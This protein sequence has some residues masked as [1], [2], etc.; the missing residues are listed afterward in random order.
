[1]CKML[2]CYFSR[3][4]IG[5]LADTQNSRVSQKSKIWT[6][7]VTKECQQQKVLVSLF[8]NYLEI[9]N[10]QKWNLDEQKSVMISIHIE[11]IT[12]NLNSKFNFRPK[13]VEYLILAN[14]T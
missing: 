13:L 4:G 14:V 3:S 1:M 10:A 6:S 11:C 7:Q 2:L 8:K 9:S 12:Y 5:L